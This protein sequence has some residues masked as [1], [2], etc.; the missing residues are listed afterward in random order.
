MNFKKDENT[1]AHITLALALLVGTFSLFSISFGLKKNETVAFYT[2]NQDQIINQE[3]Q[4]EAELE[5]QKQERRSES[6]SRLFTFEEPVVPEPVESRYVLQQ[7]EKLGSIQARSFLVGDLDTGEVIFERKPNT[8]YPI[9][10]VTKFMTAYTAAENL[11]ANEVSQITSEK[12]RVEGNR[13]R[14]QIGDTFTVRE[15]IYPLL[16]VSSNDAGEIIADQR[17]RNLF[18]AQMKSTAFDLGMF[19]TNFDDPTGL[20]KNNTSTA[21][22]LFTMMRATR[23]SY[24]QIIDISRLSFKEND[25]YFWRNINKASSFPEFRGGKTGYTNAARQTSIGYYQIAL[26]NDEIKNIA[27]VILQSNTRQQDTRN[28]LDYIKKYVAY[29]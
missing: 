21:R 22:D 28:I 3:R 8:V 14:F 19:S 15:L 27:V 29:L 5:R 6:L 24:P 25:N 23:K 17:D 10:S 11:Q 18:I 2:N 13:G 20:S 26:A 9:A 4:I 7:L 16:L 12:L 1:I